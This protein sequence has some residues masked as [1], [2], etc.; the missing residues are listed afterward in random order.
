MKLTINNYKT[1]FL[2]TLLLFLSGFNLN[3][4]NQDFKT[5]VE[6]FIESFSEEFSLS[7]ETL[8]GTGYQYFFETKTNP[9]WKKKI[10][11]KNK[12]PM[13]NK[14]NQTTYQKLYFGFYEFKNE[15]EVKKTFDGFTNCFPP[16]CVKLEKGEYIEALK[17]IPAIYIFNQ[18][19]IVTCHIGCEHLDNNWEGIKK[20]LLEKFS[21][22]E[23]TIISTGCGGPIEWL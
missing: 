9:V 13:K 21:S 7:N 19:T 1:V 11:L 12:K 22:N 2:I 20:S 14:Y 8:T 15:S 16:E 18:N 4:E 6:E 17:H 3:K 5:N 23:A 10:T